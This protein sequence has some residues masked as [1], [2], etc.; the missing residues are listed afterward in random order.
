MHGSDLDTFYRGSKWGGGVQG[1]FSFLLNKFI[2]SEF[3]RVLYS[4][5]LSPS[6]LV[7]LSQL[8][9]LGDDSQWR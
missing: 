1:L 2:K 9:G 3:S 5:P 6:R 8:M 4:S 7:Q